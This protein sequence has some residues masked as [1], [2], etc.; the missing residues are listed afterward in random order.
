[1]SNQIQ[2]LPSPRPRGRLLGNYLKNKFSPGQITNQNEELN[3]YTSTSGNATISFLE[4]NNL[5]SSSQNEEIVSGILS[6]DWNFMTEM[7]KNKF[8]FQSRSDSR[9][10]VVR[11]SVRPFVRDASSSRVK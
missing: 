11:P 5:L 9:V 4:N 7:T 1:M 3:Q 6:T 10:S 8:S 2:R